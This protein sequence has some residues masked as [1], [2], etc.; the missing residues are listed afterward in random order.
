[1]LDAMAEKLEGRDTGK[2]GRGRPP[3]EPKLLPPSCSYESWRD[4]QMPML[5]NVL[6][7][8][9]LEAA[10]CDDFERRVKIAAD[11]GLQ[12]PPAPPLSLW[13]LLR[14]AAQTP[15]HERAELVAVLSNR[16][17][18]MPAPVVMRDHHGRERGLSQTVTMIDVVTWLTGEALARGI[19]CDYATPY[20]AWMVL[21]ELVLRD[22]D[23]GEISARVHPE[24]LGRLTTTHE[25]DK[26]KQNADLAGDARKRMNSKRS[27]FGYR[28]D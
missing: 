9:E 3:R 24:R 23:I 25:V 1:M 21:A 20:Q 15:S 27:A 18:P 4:V 16:R 22:H 14:V 13:M 11:A 7:Q 17:R 26:K 8:L 28:T 12:P 5:A 2:R 10:E 6:V 19:A